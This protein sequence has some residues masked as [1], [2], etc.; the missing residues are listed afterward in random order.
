MRKWFP[1]L[2]IVGLA[3]GAC[4]DARDDDVVQQDTTLH[5]RPDTMMVERTITTD[6]IR[7][8]DLGRDTLR[9]DTLRRDTLPR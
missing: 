3:A 2:V 4:G 7:N 8:P 6:T 5:I 1:A 9:G